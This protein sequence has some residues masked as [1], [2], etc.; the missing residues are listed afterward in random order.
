MK[1]PGLR[2]EGALRPPGRLSDG[3]AAI[4]TQFQLPAEFSPAA[5]EA[6]TAA[7][8]NAAAPTMPTAPRLPFVT[9]DPSSSTDLDQAFAIEAA[10]GDLILRYAIADVGWFVGDGDAIDIEAWARGETIYLPDGK[11]S[12]YPPVLSEGAASL[13]PDGDAARGAVL[14]PGRAGRRGRLDGV[15]RAIIRSRAKLGYATV[16]PEELPAGFDELA[17][18]IAA[19]EQARGAARVDPPQQQVVER[20][21]GGFELGVPADERDR[22]KPMRRCRSPPTSPS[23]MR[24]IT[25]GT[26]LF[27]IMPEPEQACDPRGCAT[28]PRRSGSTGRRR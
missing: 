2:H 23:P 24:S 13:L 26:G 14:G 10:G 27:R 20:P 28:A 18:R 4:R 1:S 21:D 22:S 7:A 9:L 19:A 12:L 11:V 15:E 5:I 16:R 17:R 25:H 8:R 6:A 3:L